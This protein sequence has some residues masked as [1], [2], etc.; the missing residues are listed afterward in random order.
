MTWSC[1]N[2]FDDFFSEKCNE[3]GVGCSL[4]IKSVFVQSCKIKSIFIEHFTVFTVHSAI[5]KFEH[6]CTDSTVYIL[7]LCSLYTLQYV[8][9]NTVLQTVQCTPYCCVHCTLCNMLIWTLL[10]RQYSVHCTVVF[11]VHCAIC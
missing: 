5:C 9:L 11:T 4:S 8:N 6:C 7:L 3:H 2:Y 10:Y 1:R